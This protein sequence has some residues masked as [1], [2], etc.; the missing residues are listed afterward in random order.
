M[1]RRN[2]LHVSLFA[3]ASIGGTSSFAS[4][5]VANTL[6]IASTATGPKVGKA[7]ATVSMHIYN[8]FQA[9]YGRNFYF[10]V[11]PFVYE[12]FVYPGAVSLHFHDFP[13]LGTD[14]RV[15][16][17]DDLTLEMADPRNESSLAAQ[18]AMSA[19]EQ[20]KYFHMCDRLFGSYEKVQSGTYL[21]E[22]LNRMALAIELDIDMFNESMES[23][24]HIQALADSVRIGQENGI[25]AI[26]MFI[27]DNGKDEP[28]VLSNTAEGYALLKRQIE[29][30]LLAA[31]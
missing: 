22:S 16:D 13:R 20:G 17:P 9:H 24:R 1:N 7:D 25:F 19:G 12:D 18:A 30:S 26:P 4:T 3:M 15:A 6:S 14:P 28:E 21:R 5:P 31:R 29:V 27:L 2:L 11:L 8:D 10:Q 23:G